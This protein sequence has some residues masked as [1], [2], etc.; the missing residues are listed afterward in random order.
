MQ[1]TWGFPSDEDSI[2]LSHPPSRTHSTHTWSLSLLATEDVGT[3]PWTWW[4]TCE[5]PEEKQPG[6]RQRSVQK[7][8]FPLP[9]LSEECCWQ[10]ILPRP[11]AF[12]LLVAAKILHLDDLL[13]AFSARCH[14]EA[15]QELLP[16]GKE[17]SLCVITHGL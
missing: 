6:L 2:P 11:D 10:L 14:L 4:D 13:M 7:W 1:I 9:F 16:V 8:D 5:C 12:H 15:Q 3:G 17:L